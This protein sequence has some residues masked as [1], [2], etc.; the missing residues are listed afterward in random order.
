L[1]GASQQ[2]SEIALNHGRFATHGRELI[3][4]SSPPESA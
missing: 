1:S 3:V 4:R 2:Q